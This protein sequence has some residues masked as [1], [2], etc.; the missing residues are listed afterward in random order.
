MG[1]KMPRPNLAVVLMAAYAGFCTAAIAATTCEEL[2]KLQPAN[3]TITLSQTI[4]AGALTPPT[5][6]LGPPGSVVPDF[7]KL[8]A[9]CRVMASVKPTADSDIKVELWMPSEKWNGRFLGVGNGGLAGSINYLELYFGLRRGYAVASTDTGHTAPKNG[10]PEA[11]GIG[12]PEKVV[13]FGYRGIHEMTRVS[14][15]ITA[16]FYGRPAH[17]YFGSCSNGGRQA[18]MEVQRFPQDYDGVIAGAPANFFTHVGA[19]ALALGPAIASGGYIPAAKI[20]ALARA[21]NATCDANDGLKDGILTDPRTCRFDPQ[22]LLCRKAGTEDCLTTKQVATVKALYAGARDATGTQIYPGFLPGAEDGIPGWSLWEMGPAPRQGLLFLLN[23]SYY[24][25]LVYEKPDWDELHANAEQAIRLADAKTG[26][27]L[28]AVDPDLTAFRARGGKLIVYHG[29][30]DP[31]LP[32]LN[33]V[34]YYE[35]V[36]AKMGPE[37]VH[38][39]VRLYM[40]PGMQHCEAGAGPDYVGQPGYSQ[41]IGTAVE[42]PVHNIQ[43]ALEQWAEKSVAPTEIIATQY[44]GE[45]SRVTVRMTRPVCPY[46]Q[47]AT[48]TGRGRTDDAANFV[49][50][51]PSH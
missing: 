9:F 19:W 25:G 47:V 26:T 11:W 23:R 21:V 40:I 16:A 24:A 44:A 28:N 33:T 6:P 7:K 41:P 17:S 18:L 30:N 15:E 2:G 31:A 8:P 49:C 51:W 1:I 45:G 3:T 5:G 12:H 27:I 29:W 32:A 22:V 50:K 42:D 46:P 10:A 39:F 14:K 36:V 35:S 4:A 37:S 13:D 48:W 43:L 34:N 38:G 20:S